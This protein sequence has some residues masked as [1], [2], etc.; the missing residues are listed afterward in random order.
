M[1]LVTMTKTLD[2]IIEEI[3]RDTTDTLHIVSPY[4]QL[5]KRDEEWYRVTKALNSLKGSA[6]E[7]IFMI[8][9]PGRKMKGFFN[10]INQLKE[11]ASEIWLI[12]NLHSKCYFNGKKALITSLN[13]YYHSTKH[14]FEL[15]VVIDKDQ[16]TLKTINEYIEA[17][18]DVGEQILQKERTKV[19]VEKRDI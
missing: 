3:I 4:V 1:R 17:L 11:Y 16:T 19:S 15:G 10:N 18:K 8:R 13:F 5:S 14:N 7:I 6:T 2:K 9:K 12:P